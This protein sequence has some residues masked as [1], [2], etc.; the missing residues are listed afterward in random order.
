MSPWVEAESVICSDGYGAYA[1]IAKATGCEH[2]VAKTG[3]QNA[4][5]LSIGRIDAY[6]RDV[7]NLVNRRC[8]GVGTRYLMNYFGWAR[9][10]AQH[11]PFGGDFLGEM[12]EV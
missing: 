6:H 8:M 11:K 10:I 4:K 5:G 12:M 2:M 9:R 7:E 3:G 1:Q